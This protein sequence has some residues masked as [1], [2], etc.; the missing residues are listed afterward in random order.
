MSTG[1]LLVTHEDIGAQLVAVSEAIFKQR[2]T[3]I[4][5]VSIPADIG[6]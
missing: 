2:T 6:P 5:L 1:I 4:A 3:A